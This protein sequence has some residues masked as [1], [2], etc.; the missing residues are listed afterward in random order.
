MGRLFAIPVG[1]LVLVAASMWWSAGAADEP[2]DFVYTNRGDVRTLDPNRM[3]WMEDI[4]IGYALYEGLYALDPQTLKAIP[5]AAGRHDLSDDRTVY[6]FHIR[7]ES[8]WSDGSSVTSS[9]FIFAWRRMLEQPGDYTYLLD[10]IRGAKAY[11]E[12]FARHIE[13]VMARA[14]DDAAILVEKPD[15]SSVGIEGLNEKTIRLTLNHP[16]AF[17]LDLVAF[18]AYF[19]VNQ[20][21][22][23]RFAR[24]HP[25]TGLVTYDY[26]FMQPPNLV[27]NGPYR[28][29]KWEFKKRLRM[30]RNEHYWDKENVRSRV[31]EQVIV[32]D[33]KLG[34][35]LRYEQGQVDWLA[36]VDAEIASALL[37]KGRNDPE[38][39][40]RD[41]HVFPAFGTYFYSI[42]C[43]ETLKGG[44]ANPFHDVRVRKA[45]AMSLDRLPIVQTVTRAGETPAFH[46]VP[47]ALLPDYPSP[48]GLRYDPD[49]AR[50]L[51]AE[52]GYPG[53][54]G[55]PQ[56]RLTFNTGF[57]HD[58]IAQV[59]AFQWRRE[60]GVSL[61][62]EPV[63]PAI[64][65]QRLHSQEYSIARAS[66]YGDY[67]DVS[68]FT[69]KYLAASDNNDSKWVNPEYDR[70]CGQ[71]ARETDPAR[72]LAML[73]RAEALLL[74]EVPIIPVYY[75][76]NR[77]LFR[78]SVKGISLHPRNMVLFKAVYKERR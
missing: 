39:R 40:Q 76:V 47:P 18:P 62:L 8:K 56:M 23:S 49:A 16:V 1:L 68:T 42:N 58:R 27:S 14:T 4:R 51:L 30:V 63:E 73:Q 71:A 44:M 13:S 34:E 67:A 46:Y 6:T 33:N 59:A 48:E 32:D 45:L 36:D 3:S 7:P 21:A 60:L 61:E 28:L 57:G 5:G 12:Q 29:D 65:S 50:R 66:W 15:F 2:A 22:M 25:D 75:Y 72:R 35:F 43:Q 10:Y 77:Y 26:T 20:H 19:P 78:E 74:D 9:N 11:R 24:I 70:L 52:A 31:I 64:F 55:F 69:D 37:E 53:G 17:F 38:N 54:K 41:L